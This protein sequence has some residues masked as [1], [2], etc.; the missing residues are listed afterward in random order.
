METVFNNEDRLVQLKCPQCPQKL[1]SSW[2]FQNPR[3]E[4]LHVLVP[5]FGHFPCTKNLGKRCIWRAIDDT[6][7]QGD[8][9]G[10]L[11]YCKHKRQ[12]H[13]CKECGG[14]SICPH[15]NRRHLCPACKGQKPAGLQFWPWLNLGTMFSHTTLVSSYGSSLPLSRHDQHRVTLYHRIV[16]GSGGM[17]MVGVRYDMNHGQLLA[18]LGMSIDAKHITIESLSRALN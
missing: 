17:H 15:N 1:R 6:P 13:T 11:L 2:F 9:F 4:E 5:H 3:T 8:S 12:K 14:R 10:I 7:T 16:V 18:S